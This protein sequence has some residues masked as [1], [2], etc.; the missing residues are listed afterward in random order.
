MSKKKVLWLTNTPAL[1][2][3]ELTGRPVVEG[4]WISALEEAVAGSGAGLELHIA[5]MGGSEQLKPVIRGNVTY[6][7]MPRAGKVVRWLRRIFLV[8]HSRREIKRLEEVIELVK[9]DVIHVFGTESFFGLIA[10]RTKIPV[11]IQVQGVVGS[12]IPVYFGNLDFWRVIFAAGIGD[13]IVGGIFFRY[14][15]EKKR[16]AREEKILKCAANIIGRTRFDE[17]HSLE[18]N[19]RRQY[20]HLDDPLRKEFFI[21]RKAQDADPVLRLIT[22]IHAEYYKGLDLLFESARMLKDRK[23]DFIWQIVGIGPTDGITRVTLKAMGLERVPTGVELLGK[24]P[25]NE[26]AK[27]MASSDIYVHT[28]FIENP[29]NAICEAM[30]LGLPVI[31]AEVGGTPSIME[32]GVTGLFY[33]RGEA[34]E[35]VKA[36][37]RVK[38]DPVLADRMGKNAR[39]VARQRHDSAK[40]VETLIKIYEEVSGGNTAQH[41]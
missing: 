11:L 3:E 26:L 35:L 6:H 31:A 17:A 5:F 10:S 1:L 13:F 23:I 36:I 30:S 28:S 33:K 39:E 9:P 41:N 12:F 7:P 2:T 37:L 22:V 21:E 18:L 29:S 4:S 38:N 32:Y 27:L 34:G 19:P 20:F 14:F 40:I 24:L 15:L 8:I 25:A 16:A